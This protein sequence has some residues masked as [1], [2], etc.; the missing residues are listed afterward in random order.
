MH[1]LPV[2]TNE[3]ELVKPGL[4]M[5][6]VQKMMALWRYSMTTTLVFIITANFGL[7]SNECK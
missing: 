4:V 5:S 2:T 1:D 3:Y 7:V 6:S